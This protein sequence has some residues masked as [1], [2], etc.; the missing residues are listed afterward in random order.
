M[1]VAAS[2]FPVL[3]HFFHHSHDSSNVLLVRCLHPSRQP[4]SSDLQTSLMADTY[5]ALTVCCLT[6]FYSVYYHMIVVPV[7]QVKKLSLRNLK[8]GV[9]D[10]V[11]GKWRGHDLSSHSLS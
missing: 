4:C 6:H 2:L 10:L 5:M 8:E 7:L 9:Q 3:A 1:W 11:A